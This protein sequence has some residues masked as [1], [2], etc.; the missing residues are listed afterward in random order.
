MVYTTVQ[1]IIFMWSK[2]AEAFTRNNLLFNSFTIIWI[3]YITTNC[4]ATSRKTS[5]DSIFT[6]YITFVDLKFSYSRNNVSSQ[7]MNIL[8]SSCIIKQG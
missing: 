2:Q 6:F 7:P 8:P 4:I 1:D 5:Y 3:S